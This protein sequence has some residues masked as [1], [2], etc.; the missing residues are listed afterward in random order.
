MKNKLLGLIY[1]LY[2]TI[3]GFT[4]RFLAKMYDSFVQFEIGIIRFYIL[5]FICPA[6]LFCVLLCNIL[7][8]Q[9]KLRDYKY[10]KWVVSVFYIIGIAFASIVC[11]NSESF[12]MVVVLYGSPIGE[13]IILM[14]LFIF[15]ANT[16]IGCS[17]KKQYEK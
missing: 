8:I 15:A 10:Y 3:L 1:I 13:M 5:K 17:G 4:G 12:F 11:C 2:P 7:A 14:V 16:I 6:V 9:W